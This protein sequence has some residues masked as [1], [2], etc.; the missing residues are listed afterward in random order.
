MT[1]RERSNAQ[2]NDLQNV[3]QKIK[4]WSSNI[5]DKL[6]LHK[7]SHYLLRLDLYVLRAWSLSD[8]LTEWFYSATLTMG[9]YFQPYWP[10]LVIFSHINNTWSISAKLTLWLLPPTLTY[11][12]NFGKINSVVII[13]H[14]YYA[15]LFDTLT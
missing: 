15:G 10:R 1:K 7:K 9:G 4:D 14:N 3:T 5:L 8:I 11:M 2:T 13:S 6:L 12:V